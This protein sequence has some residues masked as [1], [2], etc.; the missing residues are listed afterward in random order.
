MNTLQYIL[1]GG[2]FFFTACAEHKVEESAVEENAQ[3][4]LNEKAS[5]VQWKYDMLL[6][7]HINTPVK[8]LAGNDF[9]KK[10]FNEGLTNPLSNSDKYNSNNTKSMALGIYGSD[11]GYISTYNQTQE[12]IDYFLKLKNISDELGIP[13]FDSEVI[14]QFEAAKE[15]EQKT[16]DLIFK[17]YEEMDKYLVENERYEV[18]T[19]ITAAG[20]VEGLHISL[21]QIINYDLNNEKEI[22]IEQKA[23]LNNLMSILAD[24][25]GNKYINN[26]NSDLKGVLKAF[27]GIDYDKA[28][29]QKGLGVL[30]KELNKLREKIISDVWV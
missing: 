2:L 14:E 25:K 16:I 29:D 13:V 24:F 15:D 23:V 5:K 18:L 22:L 6:V 3:N 30:Q 11:L 9:D 21:D 19:L 1:I 4:E 26:I 10:G 12:M 27:N 20:Y 7:N 17:K 8:L 28:F